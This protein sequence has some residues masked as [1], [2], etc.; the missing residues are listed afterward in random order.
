MYQTHS[1][2]TNLARIFV[3][4]NLGSAMG[5][6]TVQIMKTKMI[7]YAVIQAILILVKLASIAIIDAFILTRSATAR[8][9]AL[10]ELT[11]ATAD[12]VLKSSFVTQML[13]L[14]A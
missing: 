2:V 14:S 10:M 12:A 8:T 11:R 3:L 5:E 6:T 4:G 7:N 13:D 9:S 1:S